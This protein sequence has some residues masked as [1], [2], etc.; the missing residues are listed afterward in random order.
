MDEELILMKRLEML[1]ARHRELDTKIQELTDAYNQ[2]Q[3]LLVRLKK[4]KL[5]LRDEMLEL[6][7][8]LYPDIIA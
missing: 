8:L 7:R 3:L 5:V 2:D 1:R 4:Q 6:E